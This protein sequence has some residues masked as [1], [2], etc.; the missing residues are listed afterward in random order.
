MNREWNEYCSQN[1]GYDYYP[2]QSYDPFYY[3]LPHNNYY[4][5]NNIWNPEYTT[6]SQ[7]KN[8]CDVELD[9]LIHISKPVDSLIEPTIKER[10]LVVLAPPTNLRDLID[11]IENNEVSDDID[12]NIDLK[13]MK[14]IKSELLELRDMVGMEKM[15]AA[16]FQQLVYFIQNLHMGNDAFAGDFKHTVILGPPGTGKTR[17]AKI[18]GNMYAKLGILKKNV[19]KKVT[20][21]DLIAGYLGQTAIKTQGVIDECLGG[22][23][24]IDE[25]YSLASEDKEDMFSKECIDTLCECLSHHKDNLMVIIAGYESELY[26]RFFAANKGLESRFIW[27]FKID[28]YNAGELM[29]IFMLNVVQ[30]GWTF[31]DETSIQE[32]WFQDKKDKFG[33]LG[34]DMEVLFTY[35]K[36]AHSLRIYGKD[37]ESRKKISLED[38]DNGY[39]TFLDNAKSDDR[40][41]FIHSIYI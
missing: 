6:P 29:R 21:N 37:R 12:Y 17:V 24:F 23:L 38:M 25:A 30:S 40:S 33:G 8:R 9:N 20:R 4:L 22:V 13:S 27:K 15:K 26:N 2:V 1:Y 5:P 41:S 11:I 36:M 39:K 18:I 7:V 10:K 34:R 16:I 32:K 14:N 28:P 3:Y 35:T 19:F 31:L